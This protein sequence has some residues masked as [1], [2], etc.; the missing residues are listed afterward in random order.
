MPDPL[1][2][3]IFIIHLISEG[4]LERAIYYSKIAITKRRKELDYARLLSFKLGGQHI[5]Y[6]SL[7]SEIEESKGRTDL[8]TMYYSYSDNFNLLNTLEKIVRRNIARRKYSLNDL[9]LFNFNK[10]EVYNLPQIEEKYDC[11]ILKNDISLLVKDLKNYHK[12]IK[13]IQSHL[14]LFII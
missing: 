11:E 1:N 2:L 5:I 8:K 6:N 12:T 3:A 9:L 4:R 13:Y 14:N 10:Q 7:L